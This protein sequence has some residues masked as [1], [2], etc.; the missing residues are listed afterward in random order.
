VASEADACVLQPC[1]LT[2]ET[3]DQEKK[4]KHSKLA[5]RMEEVIS[6]PTKI[7]VKLKVRK[8]RLQTENESRT[9]APS[10][11]C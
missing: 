7:G 3:V 11:R 8:S 10:P 2:A 4:V 9:S 5:E 1:A 6:E